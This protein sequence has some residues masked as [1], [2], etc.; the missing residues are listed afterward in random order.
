M[1]TSS[2]FASYFGKQQ[3]IYIKTSF[4]VFHSPLVFRWQ[5][6]YNYGGVLEKHITMRVMTLFTTQAPMVYFW[7]MKHHPAERVMKQYR[8][9]LP[10][11][12]CPTNGLTWHTKLR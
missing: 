5:P 11:L 9:S 1:S 7:I 12:E 3:Y 8:W 10:H 6:Y 4:L 2:L